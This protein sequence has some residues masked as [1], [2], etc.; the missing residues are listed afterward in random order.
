MANHIGG[1]AFRGPVVQVGRDVHGGL[2]V[3]AG[4]P[5][6]G[7]RLAGYLQAAVQLAA[8][9]PYPAVLPGVVPPLARIHLR[10]AV[11][12]QS[13]TACAAEST[14]SAVPADEAFG[15][16]A[17]PTVVV[18]EPGGGKSSLLRM[19]L[20]K[21]C[22]RWLGGERREALPVIVH[23]SALIAGPLADC[24]ARA[25]NA[26]LPGLVEEVPPDF[27]QQPPAAGTHWLV[28][29]D[30]LDELP[31]PRDMERVLRQVICWQKTHPDRYRFVLASRPLADWL[32]QF[33]EDI[34]LYELQ[35]FGPAEIGQVAARWFRAFG[36]AQP[37]TVAERFLAA[38]RHAGLTAPA[39]APLMIAMLCQLHAASPAEGLPTCRGALY[40]RFVELLRERRRPIDPT[41]RAFVGHGPVAV[42]AADRVLGELPEHLAAI[43][44]QLLFADQGARTVLDMLAERVA[45]PGR[46][47][48]AE[49][50]RFLLSALLSTGLLT[51]TAGGHVVA[52][53]SVLEFL[54][55]RHATRSPAVRDA[56]LR[57]AF[58]AVRHRGLGAPKG[59]RPRLSQWRPCFCPDLPD[60][61]LGFIIDAAPVQAARYLT[62]LAYGSAGPYGCWFVVDQARLGTGLPAG[63]LTTALR[64]L[65]LEGGHRSRPPHARVVATVAMADTWAEL[66]DARGAEVLAGL[67][68]NPR[69]R[70]AERWL[71]AAT[72]VE[73][74][75][76]RGV[77]GLAALAV[78][79]GHAPGY[80]GAAIK[81]LVEVV[82]IERSIA[83]FRQ[84]IADPSVKKL[85]RVFLAILLAKAVSARAG[86]EELYTLATDL[87]LA[88]SH[89]AFAARQLAVTAGDP[90]GVEVLRSL[91]A[92]SGLRN[93]LIVIGDL[94]SCPGGPA[95]LRKPAADATLPRLVRWAARREASRER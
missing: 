87:D 8:E 77:D 2:H 22:E 42:A 72:L 31:E 75:D 73:L 20:T 33:G 65:R 95:A 41:A 28:L 18:A 83:T 94:G 27:F 39:G 90:R 19:H 57:R 62:R 48:L 26:D 54:A 15:D 55:A 43:A 86:G 92:D 79:R 7:D 58:R 60:S 80:R 24:L 46:V 4:S 17:R 23:A 85:D 84:A 25:V 93:R 35:S 59:V 38:V 81:R 71:A 70:F 37:E 5:P 21:V 30:G 9:H 40:E 3:Y 32:L 78:T 36:L 63:L 49:W 82:G 69:L 10:Q 76:T 64:E 34:T 45:A 74:G 29:V 16:V 68:A 61:Y 66:G 89:R 13:P 11:H 12:R 6:A 47:P 56:E 88:P 52:H 14:H 44:H 53:R 50:R 67:T 51:A 1:G 91:V